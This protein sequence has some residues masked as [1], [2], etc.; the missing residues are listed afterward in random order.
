MYLEVIKGK[1]KGYRGCTANGS[2]KMFLHK[3]NS[4]V[5]IKSE[6]ESID[7]MSKS[8]VIKSWKDS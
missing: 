3:G 5:D 8:R 4:H 7:I 6:L 2:S 1:Y